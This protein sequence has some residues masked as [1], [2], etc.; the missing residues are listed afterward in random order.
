MGTPRRPSAGPWLSRGV[1]GARSWE[2][3]R[4]S[5][6]PR[7]T[8]TTYTGRRAWRKACRLSSWP[9]APMTSTPRWFATIG[10][11]VTLS[12]MGNLKGARPHASAMLAL[13]EKLRIRYGRPA[14][15]GEMRTYRTLRATGGSLAT[16]ATGAWRY[17]PWTAVSSIHGHCWNT[18]WVTLGWVRCTWSGFWRGCAWSRQARTCHTCAALSQCLWLLA[19]PVWSTN[20]SGERRRGGLRNNSLVAVCDSCR[21]HVRPRRSGAAGGA[22]G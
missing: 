10:P 2:R 19:S 8:T 16:A 1:K 6:P 4:W 3:G 13:T 7:W 18:R 14:P 12:H 20:G 21:H 15:F 11:P 9:A 17:Q 5:M 22:A